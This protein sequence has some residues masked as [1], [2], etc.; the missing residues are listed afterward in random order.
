[1]RPD[2]FIVLFVFV[3]I[4]WVLGWISK[5]YWNH[6][7]YM[8]IIQFKAEANARLL[9]RLGS[10]PGVLE[11]LK[12]E[13][14]RTMF[15]VKTPEPGMP[16]PYARMLTSVQAACFLLAAGVA[17]LIYRSSISVESWARSGQAGFLFFGS[18]GIALAIGALLSAGAAFL[19]A[20]LWQRQRLSE[21]RG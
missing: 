19:S 2:G 1:M 17:C 9:D 16:T 3:G 7:R 6:Q 15:D 10:D 20:R 18:M 8:K 5:S 11:L 14:Q 12:S 4:P 21:E 13:A